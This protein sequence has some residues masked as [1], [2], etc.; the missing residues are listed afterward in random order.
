[1]S[2][3]NTSVKLYIS[4][5]ESMG[6]IVTLN[7]RSRWKVETFEKS[8]AAMWAMLDDVIVSPYIGSKYTLKN[9]KRNQ[10]VKASLIK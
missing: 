3:Y 8:T 4:Q 7:D 9:L 2:Y 10:E 5:V 1:M 6:E